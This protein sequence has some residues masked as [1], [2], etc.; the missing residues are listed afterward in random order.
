MR[1]ALT[2]IGGQIGSALAARLSRFGQVLPLDRAA[3]DLSRP[4]DIPR[5]LSALEPGLIVNAAAYTDVERA[6]EEAELAMRINGEAPAALARWARA[7]GVPLVHFSTDYVFDGEKTEPY[8]EDDRPNPINAY[9]R[10]KLA[11]EAAIRAESA[12]GLIVRTAWVY[13]ARGRN[14]MLTMLRLGRERELLRVVNDQFGAPTP[15]GV[16]AEWTERLIARLAIEAEGEAR[17]G[18]LTC[19]LT[20]GGSTSW[21]GFAQAIMRAAAR[22]DPRFGRVYV[23]PIASAEYPSRVRRPRNSRLELG[24]VAG[25][26]GQPPPLWSEALEEVVHAAL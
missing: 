24:R 17:R 8:A 1:I 9:G 26:L 4:D 10:S 22:R 12:N 20:C 15:A 2:G 13:A 19:H 3:L 6:E 14:F 11:G 23:E 16:I 7:R 21:C 25:W 5:R 18:L